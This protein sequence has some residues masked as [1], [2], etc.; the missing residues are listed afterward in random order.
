MFFECFAQGPLSDDSSVFC[1][2]AEKSPERSRPQ[3]P[4]VEIQ[5][6]P[7]SF[8]VYSNVRQIVLEQQIKQVSTWKL[9]LCPPI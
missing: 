7:S 4:L 5:G 6:N 8:T 2:K 3:I 1:N 9:V